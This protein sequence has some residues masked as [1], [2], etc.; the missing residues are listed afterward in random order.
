MLK[1]PPMNYFV[2]L[3]ALLVTFVLTWA[4]SA[5][6]KRPVR[7]MW[8]FFVVVFLATWAGQLWITPFG[9]QYW[10]VNVFSLIL[11]AVFFSLFIF[12]LVP[13]KKD[14]DR[15]NSAFFI[16]GIFF[17]VMIVLLIAAIG[18]GYYYRSPEMVAGFYYNPPRMDPAAW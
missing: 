11:V 6:S 2:I 13:L 17:W 14:G 16:L 4:L 5:V 3:A 1:T 8:V 18:A 7:G 10:G 15:V 12:T 9:P